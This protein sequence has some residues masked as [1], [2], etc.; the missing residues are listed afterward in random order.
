MFYDNFVAIIAISQRIGYEFGVFSGFISVKFRWWGSSRQSFFKGFLDSH[1]YLNLDSCGYL[2]ICAEKIS[3]NLDSYSHL[4]ES[5]GVKN[6]SRAK[7]S[8]I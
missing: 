5:R 2:K 1:S 4:K 6:S 8:E 7:K 3:E